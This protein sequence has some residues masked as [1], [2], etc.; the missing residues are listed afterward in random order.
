[1]WTEIVPLISGKDNSRVCERTT[2]VDRDK[3][4]SIFQHIG[5]SQD[6]DDDA[7]A[8]IYPFIVGVLSRRR[9][10]PE[11]SA[12]NLQSIAEAPNPRLRL[13]RRRTLGNAPTSYKYS[14]YYNYPVFYYF[15]CVILLFPG[16]YI[17]ANLSSVGES[18]T[19]WS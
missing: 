3:Q 8:R 19:K 5:P 11:E 6:E 15:L 7:N 4:E 14:T 2:S 12:D 1:M 13:R 17:L 18:F 10:S 16:W 9:H